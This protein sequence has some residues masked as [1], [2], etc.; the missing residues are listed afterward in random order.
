METDL[1]ENQSDRTFRVVQCPQDQHGGKNVGDLGG[2]RYPGGICFE[3]DHEKQIEQHI[4]H[5]GDRDV[6]Q[7]PFRIAYR[8][9]DGGSDDVKDRKRQPRTTDLE[10]ER[11]FIQH[12][13]R[14]VH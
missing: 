3:H 11:G 1:L 2:D 7:R 9:Q 10:V 13:I 6:K 4:D 14:C 5:P 8:P 12:I